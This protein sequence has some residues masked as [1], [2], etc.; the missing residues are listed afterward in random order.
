M[1]KRDQILASIDQK[2]IYHVYLGIDIEDINACI[3]QSN[4]RIS[5]PL[6]IDRNP[7]LSFKYYGNKL[8]LRDFADIRFRGDIFEI[9]GY[10]LNLNCRN[11]A[12][13]QSICDDIILKCSSYSNTKLII[14]EDEHSIINSK[15]FTIDIESRPLNM[16]DIKYWNTQGLLKDTVD[17]FIIPVGSYYLN[18]RYINYKYRSND[19]CYAYYLGNHKFKLYFPYRDKKDIKFITNNRF[20]IECFTKIGYRD[21]LILTKAYKDNCLIIQFLRQLN[22]NNIQALSISGETA[23]L[24]DNILKAIRLRN[25]KGIITLFDNDSVGINSTKYYEE[26]YGTIPWYFALGYTG[27]DPTGM[28]GKVGYNTTLNRFKELINSL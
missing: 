21:Y 11:P 18:G 20:P 9:V 19:P 25:P 1:T 13:F 5:N 15:H 3:T 26:T 10:V 4:Y 17:E 16:S 12:H 6:R 22:I 14:S 24:N 28:V 2:Y 8:I 27:K 7:S 23:K